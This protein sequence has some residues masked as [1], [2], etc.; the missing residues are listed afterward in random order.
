MEASG[1]PL[2]N[3]SS[4][5]FT[6][7]E[8]IISSNETRDSLDQNADKKATR[9]FYTTLVLLVFTGPLG[10]MSSLYILTKTVLIKSKRPMH[11]FTI[12]RSLVDLFVCGLVIPMIISRMVLSRISDNI[13]DQFCRVIIS[14]VAS[15]IA[16][17]YAANSAVAVYCHIKCVFVKAPKW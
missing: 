3:G 15:G 16:L 4:T 8:T 17:S 12:N 11:V 10:L 9:I 14:F 7:A 2:L 1:M 13:T 6:T 5:N